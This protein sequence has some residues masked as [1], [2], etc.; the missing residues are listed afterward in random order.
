M[1]DIREAILKQMHN[2]GLTIYQVAKLVEKEVPQR[3]VYAF[4]T[5]EKDTGTKT[6][7]IIMRALG[8]NIITETTFK[9]GNAA[10]GRSK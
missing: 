8:L 1:T 3:T 4:L 6:A 9:R 2:S 5:G 7:S 10:E